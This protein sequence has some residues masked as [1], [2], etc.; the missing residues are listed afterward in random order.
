MK[1]LKPR[2]IV[3]SPLSSRSG[4]GDVV[5]AGAVESVREQPAGSGSVTITLY[6]DSHYSKLKAAVQTHFASL[7]PTS[8]SASAPSPS[9]SALP[10]LKVVKVVLG[11]DHPTSRGAA[12]KPSTPSSSSSS[13]SASASAAPAR[14]PAAAAQKQVLPGLAQVKHILAVSS[15]KG[16][17]R[18]CTNI[19]MQRQVLIGMMRC[20]V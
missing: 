13:A 3:T 11:S 8:T 4:D 7:L 16:Q 1:S 15:C 17:H 19:L 5:Y 9:A 14:P 20:A 12:R 6:L 2:S 10:W 18:I